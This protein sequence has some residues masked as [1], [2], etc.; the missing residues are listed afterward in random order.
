M[1]NQNFK[2]NAP[3]KEFRAPFYKAMKTSH[4]EPQK[5]AQAPARPVAPVAAAPA[6][7]NLLSLDKW[8]ETVDVPSSRMSA[9]AGKDAGRAVTSGGRN[10]AAARDAQRQKFGGPRSKSGN[11]NYPAD[12]KAKAAAGA[13]SARSEYRKETAKPETAGKASPRPAQRGGRSG[14]RRGGQ[15]RQARPPQQFY[16]PAAGAS[17]KT[18]KVIPI[19][20]YEEVGRNMT[21]F[22]YGSDIVILDMGI[23]FPEEDMP[24]ISYI[25]PNVEYLK[26]KEK[27]I[28]GVIFS[29][30]HLDHIGAAPILLEKLGNPTIVGR[31]L[32]LAMVKHRQED[33]KKDSA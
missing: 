30:G 11:Y 10:V 8:L 15:N 33:Y 31:P 9:T 4:S 25:V 32:T 16:A 28:K 14:D 18:L 26:G 6:D 24:G 7:D 23:Q 20:G 12:A 22:E 19:G 2:R 1:N 3:R 29:H 21:V 17:D 5:K 27:N 13:E